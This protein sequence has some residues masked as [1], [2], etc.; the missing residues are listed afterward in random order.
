MDVVVLRP[1]DSKHGAVE[2]FEESN[3]ARNCFG[4]KRGQIDGVMVT[5][6]NF[7]EERAIADTL[8]RADLGVPVLIQ[9]TPD[10][11]GRC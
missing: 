9:A 6:P 7:G 1:E 2:T 4:K 3:A 5:L 11:P 8:R 10:N